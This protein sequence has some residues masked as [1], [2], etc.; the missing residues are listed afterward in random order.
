MNREQQIRDIAY[1]IWQSEG[2]PDGRDHAHWQQAEQQIDRATSVESTSSKRSK[3]TRDDAPIEQTGDF[4]N[5]D[6]GARTTVTTTR[7]TQKRSRKVM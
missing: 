1:A 3:V 5:G 2:R 6:D 4:A 7:S